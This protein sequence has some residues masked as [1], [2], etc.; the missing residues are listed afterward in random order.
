MR[1]THLHHLRLCSYMTKITDDDFACLAGACLLILSCDAWHYITFGDLFKRIGFSTDGIIES[2]IYCQWNQGLCW[3]EADR[4]KASCFVVCSELADISMQIP[5]AHSHAQ[6]TFIC[7]LK[8]ICI[9]NV[10]LP[11]LRMLSFGV[12]TN[13]TDKGL[14]KGFGQ[15]HRPAGAVLV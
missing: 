10:G 12:V 6:E 4:L 11:H 7:F 9:C 15:A 5:K 1:L 3:S 8:L 14:L 2:S 13:V